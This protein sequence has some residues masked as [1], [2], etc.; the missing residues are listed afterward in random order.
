MFKLSPAYFAISLFALS[1]ATGMRVPARA[2]EQKLQACSY[3]FEGKF[4]TFQSCAWRDAK[5]AL[6]VDRFHLRRMNYDRRGLAVAFVDGWNYVSRYGRSAAVVPFDNSA[7][8]F[9]DGFARSPLNGKI[10]YI[11]EQLDLVIPA[12]F[13]GAFPFARGLAA[14][15]MDCHKVSEGE[16]SSYAGGRWGCIDGRGNFTVALHPAAGFSACVPRKKAG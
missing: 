3:Q 15:C 8:P 13:D 14:V 10:G 12:R 4:S 11:D 16:H 6:Y 1:L 2:D 5:G 9:S 7:D